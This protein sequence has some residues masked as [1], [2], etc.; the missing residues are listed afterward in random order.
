MTAAP[1]SFRFARLA[2]RAALEALQ[3]RASLMWESDR[4]AILANPDAIELP[5]AQI[6]ERR[7][8]VAEAG[9]ALAGFSATLPRGDGDAELDGLFVEPEQWRRGLGRS[10]VADA[11]AL[12][13]PWGAR[14]VWVIANPNALPFYRACGFVSVGE[15]V[16]RFGPGLVMTLP[17][18]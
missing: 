8:R 7:V 5:D 15:A 13:K 3:R 10:L 6:L 9:G 14:R 16:T 11:A 4:A 17:I 18:N 1:A 12:A 2:E